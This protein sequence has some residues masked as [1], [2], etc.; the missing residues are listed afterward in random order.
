M[1]YLKVCM[2]IHMKILNNE[3]NYPMQ[4]FEKICSFIPMGNM[5]MAY[6]FLA[7]TLIGICQSCRI[8]YEAA[9]L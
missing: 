9:Q 1:K 5:S 8:N 7:T 3:F 4:K 6:K 2:S